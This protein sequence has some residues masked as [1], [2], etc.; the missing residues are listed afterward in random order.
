M[1]LNSNQ[2][3]LSVAQTVDTVRLLV[4]VVEAC[5]DVAEAS[6]RQVKLVEMGA[7]VLAI[8]LAACDMHEL[9]GAGIRLMKCLLRGGNQMA[10]RTVF[11]VGR[12]GGKTHV[13]TMR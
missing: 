11:E 10:Q 8:K 5:S 6:R 13:F 12:A 2:A 1:I 9:G 3:H 4:S 7:M